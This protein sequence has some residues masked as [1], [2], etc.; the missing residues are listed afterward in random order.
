MLPALWSP[1]LSCCR[2]RILVVPDVALSSTA[3]SGD[4]LMPQQGVWHV[5]GAGKGCKALHAT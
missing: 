3:W 2:H 4:L 1:A 5:A